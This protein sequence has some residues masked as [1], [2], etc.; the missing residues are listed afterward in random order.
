MRDMQ[1]PTPQS[2]CFVYFR[3]SQDREDRQLLSIP[4]QQAQVQSIIDDYDFLPI[5]LPDE[6]QTAKMPGR[7]IFN[8]MMERIEADEARYIVVWALSRLSRNPV[9]GARVIYAMDMGH[10][11][12]VYTPSRIY[13][14]TPEDKWLL[15]IELANAKKNNDDLSVQVKEGFATK[16]AYGQYPGPAPLGFVN[17]IISPGQRN[18]APDPDKGPLCVRLCEMA[19]TGTYHVDDLLKEARSM[20]LTSRSGKPIS[21]QTLID[22]LQRRTNIGVFQYD[23]KKEWHK[24]SYPPLISAD[25]YDAV[26]VGMGWA[27]QKNRKQPATTSGRYYPYKGLFLCKT[28]RH[29]ITAYPKIKELAS[30]TTAEYVYYTCTKKSQTIK[31]E[32]KQVTDHGLEQDVEVRMRE[33]GITEAAGAECSSWLECH[34]NDY[35]K[36]HNQDRPQWLKDN[37]KAQKAL[38]LLDE[39]LEDGTISDER[40]KVRAAIHTDVL[41]RTNEL[42]DTT[43][44]DAERWLELAK[45]TFSTA[46]NIGDVFQMAN[47]TERRRLMMYIGSNWYLSNKKVVLTEREPL[48]LLR[49]RASETN[50]RARPDSNRRSPP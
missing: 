30:G 46:I 34:Y 22:M 31:C 40:Y 45:E 21:K 27:K 10:L 15:Q 25:L 44:T 28:C 23:G 50:W 4:K 7:P 48:D 6:D 20:G 29:S 43:D 26:Q 14:D 39:K 41:A 3:R 9:D 37:Q 49:N 13:R 2:K 18:I 19:A 11:L 17:I 24:G 5:Q 38:D 1:R 36:K 35:I 33:Y 42:L 47:Y 16:R 12:A 8:D 32:E